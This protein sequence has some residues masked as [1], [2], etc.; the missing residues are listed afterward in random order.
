M[1]TMSDVLDV[2]RKWLHLPD[3]GVVE[4]TLGAVAANRMNGDPVWLSL[5]GPPGSGKTETIGALS[6]LPHIHHA[7]T[8][9]EAALLSGTP[10]KDSGNAKGGLL[11]EVGDFGI[12]VCKDFTSVLAMNRDSRSQVLAA[13]REIYDGSWTRHVGTDGG[14]VLAW[15]GKVGLIAGCTPAIDSH[16]AVVGA[17]G[18]RMALYRLPPTDDDAQAARALEHVDRAE[19]MR[20]EMAEAVESLF[21]G[22]DGWHLPGRALSSAEKTRLIDLASLAVRCRSA[23]DRDTYSREIQLVPEHEAPGRLVIM[24]ARLLSGL[25]LVGVEH[26]EAWRVLTTV[27]LSSMPAVRRLVLDRLVA[28]EAPCTTTGMATA[29]GYPTQTV[30]RALEDLACHG[31]TVRTTAGK[32]KADLYETSDWTVRRWP[33]DTVPEKPDGENSSSLYT[34]F[35]TKEGISGTPPANGLS[36]DVLAGEH[37]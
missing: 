5:V 19:H 28:A 29:V 36:A 23:V 18:E 22:I 13:L 14:R 2:F 31:V 7:A 10:K 30:R 15:S 24:L 35:L 11:R 1:T 4:V 25:E 21:A 20:A 26:G 3:G 16:H 33:G 6:R 17:M 32:G 12:L 9:T 34:S 37:R 27:A 8:L